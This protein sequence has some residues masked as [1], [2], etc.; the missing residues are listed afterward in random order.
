MI[1]LSTPVAGSGYSRLRGL[2]TAASVLVWLVAVLGPVAVFL[3][4]FTFGWNA[5]AATAQVGMVLMGGGLIAT[6]LG[7]TVAGV[8]VIA[9]LWRARANAAAISAAPHRL[10]AGWAIAGW[11][12]PIANLWVPM[13]VVSDVVCAT[14]PQDAR[15]GTLVRLWWSGWIGAWVALWVALLSVTTID[16]DNRGAVYLVFALLSGLSAL[17]FGVAAAAFTGIAM[18]V[19]RR[20]DEL[21]SRPVTV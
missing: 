12:V 4:S 2:A 18:R 3:S 19:A 5:T 21:A 11:F 9:W 15:L 8:F 10:S 1:T 20:Q 13:I 17:L 16:L 14:A 7:C 6:Y